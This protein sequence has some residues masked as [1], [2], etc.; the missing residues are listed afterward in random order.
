VD[1]STVEYLLL[2]KNTDWD[3]TMLS[4]TGK[5]RSTGHDPQSGSILGQAYPV[6]RINVDK[7]CTPDDAS[8]AQN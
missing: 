3:F 5:R 6:K 1:T 2:V 4:P 8:E 7:P